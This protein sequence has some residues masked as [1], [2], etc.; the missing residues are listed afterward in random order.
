[1]RAAAARGYGHTRIIN[2]RTTERSAEF[3]APNR[4]VYQKQGEPLKAE[5]P[6][7]LGE[8]LRTHSGDRMTLVFTPSNEKDRLLN[9]T[10]FETREIGD[11][12][13]VALIA[14]RVRATVSLPVRT[15]P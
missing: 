3:Y 9:D 4:V 13:H 14:A 1:M 2:L 15:R 6:G 12:T 5:T 8:M 10:Q 7:E 11:N